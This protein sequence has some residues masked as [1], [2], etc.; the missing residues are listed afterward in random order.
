MT[1]TDSG[2]RS[3]ERSIASEPST[4]RAWWFLGSLA[5]LRNPDGAPRTP[6]V[7]EL[8]VPPGGSPPEHVHESLD[9]S[10]LLLDGEAVVRCGGQTLVA[11]PGTYVSL[12]RGIPHTFR[13]TSRVPARLLLVHAD[14]S[15]LSFVETLGTPT[16]EH[17]LPPP[18]QFDLDLETLQQASADHGAPMIGPPL[19]EEEARSYLPTSDHAPTL[20]AVN[21]IALTVTDLRRSEDWYIKAFGLMRVDGEIADEGTGHVALLHP[22]GG[23]IMALSSGPVPAVEHVAFTCPDRE[24]LVQW[25]DMLPER[26]IAPGSITDA[27]YGSGMVLRDPDG[28]EVELFAPARM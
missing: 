26:G 14:D 23:W 17:R 22:G 21:H 3:T 15:F 27:P 13:V 8:T 16:T 20:G 24:S 5:V 25:R 18:G 19:G 28:I 4:S 7:L 10:F 1:M 12:P 9:D 2:V 11:R 6:V